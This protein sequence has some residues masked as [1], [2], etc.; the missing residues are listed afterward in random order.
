MIQTYDHNSYGQQSFWFRP[1]SGVSMAQIEPSSVGTF[2]DTV[3]L[4]Q[5]N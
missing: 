3:F 4:C 1:E 5:I 2:N